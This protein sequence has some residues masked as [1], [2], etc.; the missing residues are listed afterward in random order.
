MAK[1]TTEKKIESEDRPAA[2]PGKRTAPAATAAPAAAPKTTSRHRKATKRVV[3]P[4]MPTEAEIAEL[5]YFIY[6]ARCSGTPEGDWAVA[7]AY[8]KLKM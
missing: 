5:A 8:L 1:K 7:E 3:E 4:Q 6:E 2:K